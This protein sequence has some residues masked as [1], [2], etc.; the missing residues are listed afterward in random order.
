VVATS[1]FLPVEIYELSRDITALKVVAFVINVAL[2]AYLVL[3]KHLFGVR[4]GAA[5]Y[6]A[7]RHGESLLQT[8]QAAV[9]VET[10]P[11]S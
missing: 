6:T 1:L 10:S 9:V 2:V 4:G 7:H 3:A 5:A 11:P 8:E